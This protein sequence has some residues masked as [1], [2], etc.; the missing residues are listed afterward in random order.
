MQASILLGLGV[1]IIMQAYLANLLASIQRKS[2]R[3]VSVLGRAGCLEK[4]TSLDM[5]EATSPRRRMPACIL[6]ASPAKCLKS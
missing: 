1:S 2:K 6:V 5:T 3:Y 4:N